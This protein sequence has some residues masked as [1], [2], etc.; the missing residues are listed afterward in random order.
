MVLLQAPYLVRMNPVNPNQSKLS[1]RM[2]P[3]N[4]INSNF[5]SDWIRSI[6]INPTN[7]EKFGFI[8]IDRIHS[9][10]K[11]GLILIDRT[12]SDYKL[13]GWRVRVFWNVTEYSNPYRRK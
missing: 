1:T 9:D 13:E 10:C 11:F 12:H 6:R 2:N 3:I 5:R 8:W 4:P 7:S